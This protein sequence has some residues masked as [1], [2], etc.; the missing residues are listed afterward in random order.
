MSVG[1][2]LSFC[3]RS[4]GRPL[5]PVHVGAQRSTGPVDRAAAAAADSLLLLLNPLLWLLVVDFLSLP[6]ILHLGEDFSN[7]SRTE[8]YEP[9][10]Q[11]VA[12]PVWLLRTLPK[13]SSHP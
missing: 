3:G 11:K 7:L 6:T 10:T 9:S 12:A 1:R 8:T 13:G 2:P 5:Q 4:G